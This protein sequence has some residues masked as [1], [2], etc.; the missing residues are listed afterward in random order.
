M[1]S[2]A[3]VAPAKPGA[4]PAPA[5]PAPDKKAAAQGGQ[6]VQAQ[7]ISKKDPE[8]PK[9]ARETGAKGI[10]ELLA[11]IGTDGKVKSVK[12]VKGPPMLQKAASD[13]VLQWRYKPTMLNGV[14]VEA[15]TQVFVNFLGGDR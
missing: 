13:A 8:Y 14:A 6:L 11:M 1:N 12:V 4:A 15:Q 10:V 9:L 2:S 7:L 5:A 3:P